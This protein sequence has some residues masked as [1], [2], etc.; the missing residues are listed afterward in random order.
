MPTDHPNFAQQD[1]QAVEAVRR[2][3][4]ERFRELVERHERRVYAVA[5][6]RLGDATLAEEATQEAFIRGYRYL[7][8]LGEGEKFAAWI[9]AIA[10]NVAINLGTRHR[11]EL[12]KRARWALD[13]PAASEPPPTG[14]SYDQYLPRNLQAAL[15]GLPDAQRECLVLFYFEG[16]SGAE[17]AAALGVSEA[18]FRVRLHRARSVLRER[19]E[20]Q[21]GVSLEQ[22]RPSRPVTPL[23][24]GVLLSSFTT[25]SATGAGVGAKLLSLLGK[26]GLVAWLVP[27][28][29]VV[30]VLPSLALTSWL[31]SV[32][33]RNYREADG[34][35]ARLHR[36][37]YRSYLWGF[38]LL[39]VLLVAFQLAPRTGA[40]LSRLNLTVSCLGLVLTLIAGRLL[41]IHRNQFQVVMFAYCVV[42]TIGTLAVGLNWIPQRL[43]QLPS[44]TA[45]VLFALVLKQRPIRMDYNL[46]LRAAQGLLR[47]RATTEQAPPPLAL[48]RP[49]LLAFARFLGSRWLVM[50]FQ[51]EVRGLAL[52]LP[53]ARTRF[54][55]GLTIVF[56]P[57]SRW[58]SFVRLGWDGTVGAHCSNADAR[59]L[60]QLGLERLPTPRE[61]ED[62]VAQAVAQAWQ[63]F[64]NGNE[65]AA[66]RTLGQIPD[67]EV[68]VVPVAKSAATRWWK[69]IL[70]GWIVLAVPLLVLLYLQPPWLEGMKP[71]NVTEQEIR[72]TLAGLTNT[73]SSL[74]YADGSPYLGFTFSFVLPTKDYFTPAAL[75]VV[76]QTTFQHAGFHGQR[77]AQVR[78]QYLDHL[79]VQKAILLGWVDWSDVGLTPAD[80][81]KYLRQKKSADKWRLLTQGTSWSWMT[82]ER[83]PV[84]RLHDYGLTKLHWLQRLDC[85]D[86][87]GSEQFIQQITATQV[88][89]G[90]P[91]PGQPPIH[92]WKNVR[93]LF[94]TPS[95]PV[96][97]D[98]YRSLRALEILGGLN[99]IDREACIQGILQHHQGRGYFTS[100]APGGYNEYKIE[101]DARDTF[102]AYEALRL[103]NAL[104]RVT[105]L[106]R[107]QF[108]LPRR[109]R[110]DAS[111]I[112]RKVT[113]EEIEAWVCQQRFAHVLREHK[114]NPQLPRHSLLTP[115]DS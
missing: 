9:V 46:F 114:A 20:E 36:G 80:A 109:S 64:R 70:V 3:D 78:L 60:A 21:I 43:G 45:T 2:G 91:A 94:H 48:D 11:R 67:S 8:L 12:N 107:W 42:I 30:M 77:D 71:V 110:S 26:S 115:P 4:A 15:A 79:D 33:R 44:L 56:V 72:T 52:R 37:Y 97:Q 23:V 7:R 28:A 90:T 65:A 27:F 99:R 14:N 98:T 40:G 76:R 58:C 41:A 10:R 104:D 38:P 1:A 54:V 39:I 34:F 102:C 113:W 49:S 18:A 95:W 25:K 92:D 87:L 75:A 35:R 108:R 105:D 31:G 6:S 103:L 69:R 106:D 19:L 50:N 81:A 5:W 112:T 47:P 22:L 101:G 96:L 29:P 93:G 68:F 82:Q 24:M 83:F 73:P 32:E 85:L 16:K 86:L 100:P 51:W 63:D 53:P 17:A 62:S 89:S 84:M 13:Q 88:L 66:E 59:D 111:A 55:R 74:A 61:L 57:L